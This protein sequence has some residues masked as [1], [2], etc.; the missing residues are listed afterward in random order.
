M[1]AT[2]HK[3]SKPLL[4][5]QG[6]RRWLSAARH[7]ARRDG[8]IAAALLVLPWALAWVLVRHHHLDVTTVTVLVALTVPL[9]TLSLTW[10]AVR[11]AS[12]HGPA[13]AGAARSDTLDARSEFAS[14]TGAAGD[15]RE[16]RDQF[17]ALVPVV[18]RVLGPDHP[19]TLD[20]RNNLVS[21]T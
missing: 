9:A 1:S 7:P 10:A 13:D 20:A 3:S 12:R 14:S 11:N 2:R 16:H 5:R 19:K 15:P 17:A 21:W 18:A 6:L 4:K 8:V